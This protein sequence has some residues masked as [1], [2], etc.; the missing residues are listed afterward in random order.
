MYIYEMKKERA[1]LAKQIAKLQKDLELLPNQKL[2][3]TKNGK[4]N[5]WYIANG[6]TPV[7]IKKNQRELAEKLA[8][9]EITEMN[10]KN[11]CQELASMDRYIKEHEQRSLEQQKWFTNNS[12]LQK[13][14]ETSKDFTPDSSTDEY[15][16]K[17]MQESYESN[18]RYPEKL[19]H[20]TMDGKRVRSKSEVIIANAL[21]HH[22]IPY[23]Y[24]C[25]FRS[26]DMTI[27]PDFT[28]C[29]PQ[30]KQIFYWEHFGMMDLSA[31]ANRAFEKLKMYASCQVIPT[32]NLL[33]T[34]ETAYHQLDCEQVENI[35]KETFL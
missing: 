9:R 34:Y 4:Y 1:H 13:L 26:E 16:Q 18:P 27:Y 28:I 7:Y 10:L 22:G 6:H 25:A 3:I 23:R 31:Y 24:E 33:T 30:N 35:I 15:L 5:K 11:A 20:K 19:I 17:W 14:L 29:H 21:H 32:I 8:Q 12:E 2:F